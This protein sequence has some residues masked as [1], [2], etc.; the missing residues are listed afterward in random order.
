MQC[1][2]RTFAADQRPSW[3]ALLPRRLRPLR[4]RGPC[5]LHLCRCRHVGAQVLGH[6]H[7]QGLQA[8][9]EGGTQVWCLGR[10]RQ[11]AQ[12]AAPGA[13][14][15]AFMVHRQVC[16]ITIQLLGRHSKPQT[17]L[18]LPGPGRA[19]MC[20]GLSLPPCC[21]IDVVAVW[22]TGAAAAR[23]MPMRAHT[24]MHACM[25]GRARTLRTRTQLPQPRASL[26]TGAAPPPE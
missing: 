9:Q 24:C 18:A 20:G 21:C 7:G 5:A 1:S 19:C 22:G 2:G 25:H 12:G 13:Q 26:L 3:P 8:G 14:L 10:R 15:R 6:A 4:Q 23:A 17:L 16:A 11:G